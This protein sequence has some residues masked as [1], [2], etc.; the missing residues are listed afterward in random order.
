[1]AEVEELKALG[2]QYI[3]SKPP[4][5]EKAIEA[6]SKALSLDP[7][8]HTILSNRS[9]AHFKLS[10]Y[11]KA[12]E[13][14]EKAVL[15]CPTWAKGYLRK[16]AAL[17][18]LKRYCEA[19]EA[20]EAGYRLMHSTGLCKDFVAQWLKACE[21]LYAI[22]ELPTY[23]PPGP[24]DL[25]QLMII[26]WVQVC[27]ANNV[28]DHASFLPNGLVVI[29]KQYWEV[30]FHCLA[31][32]MDMLPSLAL[33]QELTQ[34]HLS[35]VANEFTRVLSLF[36][37]SVGK[38][39]K[40]WVNS[41]TRPSSG[42]QSTQIASYLKSQIHQPLFPLV[43]SL[44]ALAV[45]VVCARVYTLNAA[46]TGF[47]SINGMLNCCL[48]LFD[49]S[50][51]TADKYVGLHLKVLTGLVDS[52]NRRFRPITRDECVELARHCKKIETL[53]PLLSSCSPFEYQQLGGSFEQIVATAKTLILARQTGVAIPFQG[54]PDSPQQ[55]TLASALRDVEK[56][57]TEV[58]EFA[59]KNFQDII[60]KPRRM[61]AIQ[62]GQNL[63]QLTGECMCSKP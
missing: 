3:L 29:S 2:N 32:Y 25:C 56:R 38:E 20:A 7:T 6:Y 21:A 27:S 45:T 50:V 15:S 55:M 59:V 49:N 62:D 23:L 28:E 30:L 48:T 61:M 11:E 39:L 24:A 36:G 12:L 19:Q 63:L 34:K 57:P 4:Q 35:S 22:E 41:I 60:R 10:K 8:H 51:L 18:M 40:D 33:T 5:Y 53:M 37:Q 47:S 1:M 16:C 17:N 54:V 44:L 14:A 46:S 52:Y 26:K 31:S 43:H 58:K 42:T 13:D 9:L